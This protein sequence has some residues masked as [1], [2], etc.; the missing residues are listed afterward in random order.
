MLTPQE[1][2]EKTFEKAVFG[3]YDMQGVDSFLDALTEDYQTLYNENAVLKSKMRVLVAKLAELRD[4]S[5]AIQAEQEQARRTCEEMIRETEAKCAAMVAEADHT[6]AQS[7]LEDQETMRLHCARELA[8]SYI[9]TLEGDIRRHLD[10]L[11]S[12]KNRDMT[13]ELTQRAEAPAPEEEVADVDASAR[14][15]AQEI[16]KNLYEQGITEEEPAEEPA[17]AEAPA[18]DTTKD[19]IKFENLRFGSNYNPH[20]N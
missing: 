12:L 16:E 19:T 4:E 9:A 20:G 10:L 13:E 2:Q 14:E 3:G 15:I 5:T 6:V 7:D 8:Q 18:E 11:E 1:V 17:P